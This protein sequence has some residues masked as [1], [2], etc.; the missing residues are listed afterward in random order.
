M[1]WMIF[2][3]QTTDTWWKHIHCKRTIYK[4][5]DNDTPISRSF[6]FLVRSHEVHRRTKVWWV[7]FGHPILQAVGR[8]FTCTGASSRIC[9]NHVVPQKVARSLRCGEF[10]YFKWWILGGVYPPKI[11]ETPTPS[12][13]PIRSKPSWPIFDKMHQFD[14]SHNGRSVPILQRGPGATH[15]R[16]RF[17]GW[18]RR[19][20][21]CKASYVASVCMT[22]I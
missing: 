10:L 6:F 19:P 9:L 3:L 20:A 18:C 8:H 15:C 11:N 12:Q 21:Q 5:N 14:P 17:S 4:A 7:P 13:R 16:S 22:A 1:A 2:T